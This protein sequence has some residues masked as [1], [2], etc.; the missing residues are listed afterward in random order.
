LANCLDRVAAELKEQEA[1]VPEQLSSL[2]RSDATALRKQLDDLKA[3]Q[4]AQNAGMVVI[5]SC[6][7][8]SCLFI[9]LTI[10]WCFSS[11]AQRYY[12]IDERLVQSQSKLD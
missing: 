9:C 1:Q 8:F 11:L 12:D 4:E 7:D 2:S 3:S 5:F 10:V 6:L